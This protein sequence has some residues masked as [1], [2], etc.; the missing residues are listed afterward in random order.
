MGNKVDWPAMEIPCGYYIAH[1]V[2]REIHKSKGNWHKN[3]IM[4]K[5]PYDKT[6]EASSR[7]LL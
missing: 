5:L 1:I 2:K 7:G 6:C 3:F 4:D